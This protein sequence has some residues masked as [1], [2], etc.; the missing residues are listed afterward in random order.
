MHILCHKRHILKTNCK[1]AH[2]KTS[3]LGE[4][5]GGQSVP[6]MPFKVIQLQKNE[7]TIVAGNYSYGFIY[8]VVLKYDSR[9]LLS[10]NSKL[11]L[12]LAFPREGEALKDTVLH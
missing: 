1:A 12:A 4:W 8:K 5:R 2:V 7:K 10:E 6:W 9:V 11:L 3:I